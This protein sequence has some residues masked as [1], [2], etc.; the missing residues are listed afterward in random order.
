MRYKEGI[1]VSVL[2]EWNIEIHCSIVVDVEQLNQ[3]MMIP[4]LLL[5]TF[6]GISTFQRIVGHAMCTGLS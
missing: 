5:S 6:A 3:K 1:L 4:T 2:V